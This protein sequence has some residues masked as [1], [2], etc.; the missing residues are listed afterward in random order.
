MLIRLS[1]VGSEITVMILPGQQQEASLCM[2]GNELKITLPN[3]T[4]SPT[5]LQTVIHLASINTLEVDLFHP[6]ACEILGVTV[7]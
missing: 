3:G 7:G 6:Q 1:P 4:A 2:H 5:K